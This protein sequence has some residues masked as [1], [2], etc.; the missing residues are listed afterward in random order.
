MNSTLTS[1]L[2][3]ISPADEAAM[4]AA[5]ARQDSLA[6]PPHSLGRLEDISVKLAG[7]TGR[8]GAPV[9]RRRV[10]I[11][12]SDNG[13]V[14]AGVSSCPQS[15]TLAQ[16]INFTRGLTG[17]AVLAKHFHAELDVTDV[18]INAEFRQ[19]GVRDR[20]V[21]MGTRNFALEPAMTR[22]QCLQAM[23]A[24]IEGAQRAKDDGMQI[25]GI[26]EMG[27]GNTS[28]SS[29][30][31]SA[32]LGLPAADTVSR[33]AGIDDE[34]FKRKIRLIDEALARMTPDP[35]DPVDVLTRVGGFD[36]AAMCGAFLAAAALRLPAVID[37]F[38]SA[39]AALC[40]CRL[41]PLSAQ[42]M[43]PSHASME[44]GYRLAMEAMG[45]EPMLNLNMRLGEGSGCP[46]T[47]EICAAA[48]AVINDMATFEEAA[49]DDGYLDG[50]RGN[51]AFLGE[52]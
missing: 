47:F 27:I 17:V 18:G 29:A 21:A 35:R 43:I 51:R 30:V 3:S 20:K 24:G 33:G 45:L 42:Y 52:A 37:G 50:I 23:E 8:V 9:D 25:V 4:A 11:F 14:V 2:A 5:R 34:A 38:I 49:I 1:I 6:K 46:I 16:T 41:C 28:T 40:A 39:V 32:L 44:K 22:A 26:G 36:L 31:L 48:Q 15:V 10:L 13:I 19:P 12:A 7:I